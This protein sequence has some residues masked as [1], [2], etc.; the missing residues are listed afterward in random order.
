MKGTELKLASVVK[1]SLLECVYVSKKKKEKKEKKERSVCCKVFLGII[2]MLWSLMKAH[3]Y[4]GICWV[5]EN[6]WIFLGKNRFLQN[7]WGPNV[8]QIEISDICKLNF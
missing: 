7:L 4:A 2:D 8:R 1:W 6:R 5:S 3:K